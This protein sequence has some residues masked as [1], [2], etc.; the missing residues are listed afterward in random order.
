[1]A[2][3]KTNGAEQP[4]EVIAFPVDQAV[5]F[6]AELGLALWKARTVLDN[7]SVSHRKRWAAT[8]LVARLGALVGEMWP[9]A[10]FERPLLMLMRALRSLDGGKVEPLLSPVSRVRGGQPVELGRD[11]LRGQLV[12]T[13]DLFMRLNLKEPDA[14][15]AV[16]RTLAAHGAQVP[17]SR[18]DSWRKRA[19]EGRKTGGLGADHAAYEKWRQISLPSNDAKAKKVVE[20]LIAGVAPEFRSRLKKED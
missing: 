18:L 11:Y 10:D 1:M 5:P 4:L 8:A 16:A 6:V 19:K 13:V 17:V 12:A 3:D 7:E 14:F 15:R 20:S 9:D 2:A